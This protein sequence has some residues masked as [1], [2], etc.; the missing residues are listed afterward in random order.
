MRRRPYPYRTFKF[1][2]FVPKAAFYSRWAWVRFV[3]SNNLWE[4]YI[5]SLV[6]IAISLICIAYTNYKRRFESFRSMSYYL[7]CIWFI[8]VNTGIKNIPTSISF[9]LVILSWIVYSV[10]I[11]TVFQ[12]F[13]TSYFVIRFSN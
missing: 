11:S 8:V 10:S 4:C 3:F 9:R 7:I 13:V 2:K 12:V 6:T 5:T 1:T